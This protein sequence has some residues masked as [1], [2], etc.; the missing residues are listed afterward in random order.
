MAVQ[1]LKS[2]YRWALSGVIPLDFF[3]TFWSLH[4]SLQTPAQNG[5]EGLLQE[6]LLRLNTVLIPSR[7]LPP[8][9]LHSRS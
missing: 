7:L 4:S 2:H 9:L 1:G 5:P 6:Q 3:R 8:L